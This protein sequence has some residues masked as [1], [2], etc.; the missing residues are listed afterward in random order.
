M[1]HHPHTFKQH[2]FPPLAAALGFFDGVHLGHRKVIETAKETAGQMNW[3]SAVMTFDPHPS[4]VLSQENRPVEYITPLREKK[5]LISELGIDYLFI[6]RFTSSFAN[7]DPAQFVQQYLIGLN[8]RHVVAGFDFTYGKYGKGTMETLP[9]H[10]MGMLEVTTVA[11]MEKNSEKIS[12]TSIRKMLREGKTGSVFPFLGRY[13]E[14]KGTVVHG[15]KRGR[16]LGFPTANIRLDEDYIVPKPGVYAVRLFVSGRWEKGVCNV[17]Y[18]PTF[19]SPGQSHL[20][21]EVHLLNFKRS[22]YG[23]EVT[24][25]WRQRIRDEKK[26]QH[27]EDLKAQIGNDI[28]KAADFLAD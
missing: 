27:L 20:S 11:K 9:R 14:T 26:F 25:Q 3:K 17:G 18:K 16:L 13:Y 12:S 6:V 24:I 10:G 4:V 22:I 1:V 15:E 23:E 21:I 28:Q 2:D 7:L 5:A 19:H 8:M